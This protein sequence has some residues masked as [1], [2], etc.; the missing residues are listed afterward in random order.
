[1]SKGA[2]VVTGAS[3][4]IGRATALRLARGGHHVFAGVRRE[5]DAASIRE[6]F[7]AGLEPL[8]LEVTDPASIDAAAKQVGASVG[9][10][11]L[12]GLVNNAGITRGGPV[13]AVDLDDLRHVLEVN[14]IAPVAVTQA[15]L[16]LVRRAPGRLVFVSSIG[17][18]VAGPIIG[19][20]NASKFALEALADALR[21]E[22]R[23]WKI[24]V[25]V[26]E[27]GAIQTE[28]FG[29]ARSLKD[30]I[31]GGFSPEIRRR[32]GAMVDNVLH[33]F[34]ELEKNALDPDEVAKSIEHALTA[35]GPH[36]RYLV[37]LDARVQAVAGWLLPDGLADALRARLF[38]V[39]AEVPE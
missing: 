36:T 12:V 6:Q 15:F 22:L 21:L 5:E 20:Y 18:R 2:V 13:E 27:P 23:P 33:R 8:M 14:T 19:P 29:K 16:P 10:A 7:V 30:E 31:M 1:M 11:G 35:D 25:A 3:T 32:Y 17:G 28:I 37:G 34:D 26:I 24:H 9:G 39:P 38:G 4:G